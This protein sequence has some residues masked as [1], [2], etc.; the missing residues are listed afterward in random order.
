MKKI[1]LLLLFLAVSVI[2]IA[3]QQ[4]SPVRQGSVL[5]YNVY[6]EGGELQSELVLERMSADTIVIGW[7]TFGRAVRNGRRT[8]AGSS[9]QT[10]KHGY[11]A[12]PFDGEDILLPADQ[13]MLFMSRNAFTQAKTSGRMEYDGLKFI[14][15]S[16]SSTY[17]MG[18]VKLPAI[19]LKSE[20]GNASI[21]ILDDPSFPLMLKYSGNPFYVDLEILGV[22]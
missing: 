13:S 18:G 11:W 16:Q 15:A 7:S 1:N 5:V 17:D 19:E 20:N 22:K 3:Q 6:P 21:W 4:I 10:S 2:T 9:L 12:P 14:V 8:M